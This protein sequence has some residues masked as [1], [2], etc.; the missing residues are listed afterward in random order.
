MV[1]PVRRS[2][3]SE[4][5]A[6]R[7]RRRHRIYSDPRWRVCRTLTLVRANR[8]CQLCGDDATIADHWPLSLQQL[9]DQG[10]DPF[11]PAVCRALCARCSG[12]ADGGRTR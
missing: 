4:L 7:R 5:A 3:Q 10:H 6:K 11:D 1:N 12:H 2:I 8:T 9:V